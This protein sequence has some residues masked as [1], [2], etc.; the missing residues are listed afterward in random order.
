[1]YDKAYILET[2]NEELTTDEGREW[3][4]LLTM[5][6]GWEK[7]ITKNWLQE[8]TKRCDAI[9]D[10]D[11]DE[12]D[13]VDERYELIVDML[14]ESD[15]VASSV[16]RETDKPAQPEPPK[17]S[18]KILR[19]HVAIVKAHLKEHLDELLTHPDEWFLDD[20]GLNPT[21]YTNQVI[22]QVTRELIS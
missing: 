21:G 11:I 5:V 12:E 13:F 19:K 14:N 7:K 3:L 10:D 6:D 22:R 2:V 9:Q 18:D 16:E 20:L 15:L 1:M 8:F 4:P 17:R